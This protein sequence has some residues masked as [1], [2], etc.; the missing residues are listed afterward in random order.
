M[1]T[2]TDNAERQ[3]ISMP[4]AFKLLGISRPAGYALARRNALP[5]PVIRLGDR[6]MVVSRRA[7]EAVLDAAKPTDNAA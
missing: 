4:T 3:T 2:T 1:V 7:L 5:V 6:R